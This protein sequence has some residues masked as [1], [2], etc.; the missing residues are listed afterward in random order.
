MAVSGHL[1][2]L[3]VLEP[4]LQL[5]G[6]RAYWHSRRPPLHRHTRSMPGPRPQWLPW[7]NGKEGYIAGTAHST[8]E[9]PNRGNPINYR[10]V[11]FDRHGEVMCETRLRRSQLALHLVDGHPYPEGFYKPSIDPSGKCRPDVS[12]PRFSDDDYGGGGGG[13]PGGPSDSG[14]KNVDSDVAVRL[15]VTTTPMTWQRPESDNESDR[16]Y[17]SDEHDDQRRASGSKKAGAAAGPL[18]ATRQWDP[19]KP[20]TRVKRRRLIPS[21]GAG[22]LEQEVLSYAANNDSLRR[23]LQKQGAAGRAALAPVTINGLRH[24]P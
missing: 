24:K 10:F 17:S 3:G 4:R 6:R 2:S 16:N 19:R 23:Q 9:E 20:D 15:I 5:L 11:M 21:H 7:A 1:R 12:H 22:P 18:L 14:K 13:G 8:S